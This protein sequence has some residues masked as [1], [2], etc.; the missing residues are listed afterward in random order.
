MDVTHV[1]RRWSLVELLED[2]PASCGP[3][4]SDAQVLQRAPLDSSFVPS[5]G[6]QARCCQQAEGGKR[7]QR[8]LQ[9][10]RA[11]LTHGLHYYYL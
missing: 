3:T 11:A 8:H 2:Q 10:R 9:S 4:S 7:R 6:W 5:I 1:A